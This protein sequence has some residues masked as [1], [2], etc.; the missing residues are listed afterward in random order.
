MTTRSCSASVFGDGCIS[1]GAR[2]Q[3]LRLHLDAKYPVMNEEIKD[4]LRGCFPENPVGQPTA[5]TS[6]WSGRSDTLVILSVYSR[7]LECLFPQHGAGRK[8]E[9]EI[10]LEEWQVKLLDASPWP[11]L[12][13][14][15]RSDGC[16]SINRTGPY[17]YL[18]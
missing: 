10:T 5:P 3:R 7:H 18:S 12:R 2:T 14:C 15:I 11:F 8:H 1:E 13:G 16:A 17:E 4:L 9:R 6:A